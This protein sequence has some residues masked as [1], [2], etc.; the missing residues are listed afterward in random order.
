LGLLVDVQITNGVA[1]E[2]A[3]DHFV[4]SSR[5]RFWCRPVGIDHAV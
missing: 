1:G 2:R 3:G 4:G 5:G